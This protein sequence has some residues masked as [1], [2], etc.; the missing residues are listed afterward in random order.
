[1]NLPLNLFGGSA[2]GLDGNQVLHTHSDNKPYQGSSDA[3]EFVNTTLQSG[4]ALH[5]DAAILRFASDQVKVDGLFI[6]LGTY[7]GRTTNF[8]A[9]LNPH[10]MIYTFDSYLGLPADWDQGDIIFP[11]DCLAWPKNEPLPPFLLNVALKIG[12]FSDTLP[13]FAAL[14]DEPIAFLHV[15]CD[16]Y[17]STSQAL[18]ILGPMI[19]HETVILFDEFY[20]YPTFRD[21]E[22]RAFQEFL[23]KFSFEAEYLAYNALH[24]QAA[25][26]VLN[27]ERA[28]VAE[29]ARRE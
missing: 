20:N 24:E 26:R 14:Q 8:L 12:W 21:H 18:D 9:A 5:S 29:Q 3:T 10:K 2:F 1:M 6:E 25:V 19:V 4:I 7:K 11:A 15:D 23:K 27:L 28:I 16:I 22:Y 17:E 13:T